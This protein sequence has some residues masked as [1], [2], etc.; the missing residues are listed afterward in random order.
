MANNKEVDQPELKIRRTPSESSR[1]ADILARY[2]GLPDNIRQ[3]AS[4]P[5]WRTCM[6]CQ[7][8]FYS[9]DISR[10][11]SCE[12]CKQSKQSGLREIP[13]RSMGTVEGYDG[14][15]ES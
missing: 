4:L 10:I 9:P 13:I 3:L 6:Q 1:P 2:K 8:K 7:Q 15:K 12:V 11:R 14:G 5:G